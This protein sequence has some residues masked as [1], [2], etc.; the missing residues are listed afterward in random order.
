M[1]KLCIVGD[2]VIVAGTGSVG[3]GQRFCSLVEKAWADRAFGKPPID[4]LKSL[5]RSAIEDMGQTY[6][7]PGQ[8]GAVVAFP[9][10]RKG[11]L[12]EFATADMQPE[13]KTE[14][15]WYCSMGSS[16]AITDPFL[17]FI[18]E[19]FWDDGLPNVQD[20]VFAV[21]W[22]LRQA[23]CLNP[24]GVNEPI[25]IAVLEPDQ[26]GDLV[27]RILADDELAQHR[28]NIEEAKQHLRDF[29]RRHR[30]DAA[31]DLPEIPRP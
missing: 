19:I 23:V 4:A 29:R 22:T 30:P 9:H 20:A 1:E 17:G 31:P 24:G 13:L 26:N 5:S 25:R 12:C 8:Y 16:Q 3:L 10:K 7:K 14:A 27:A 6:L 28:Q 21:A 15:L 2:R 18:R 11:Y